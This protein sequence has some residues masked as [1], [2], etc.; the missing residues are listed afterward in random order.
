[1]FYVYEHLRNDTNAVFYVGKGKD[2]RANARTDRN[3]HWQRVVNKANG[4]SINFVAK[5]MDEELAY[6]CEQERIDQLKRLDVKLVNLTLG[7]E[8]AGSGENHHMWG[9]P[10]PQRGVKRPWVGKKGAANPMYGKPSPMR[11]KKNIG[12]SLAHKGRKRPEGGGKKPHPVVATKDGVSTH[13]G[14]IADAA[15]FMNCS[16]L[17]IRKACNKQQQFGEFMWCYAEEQS[18]Q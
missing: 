2:Y 4:F 16:R 18:C 5:D 17:D 6:L 15:R 7:G 14:S 13:F 3:I 11:G 8:G 1:M 10:H 9:K 12:A